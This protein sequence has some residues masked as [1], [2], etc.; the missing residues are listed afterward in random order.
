MTLQKNVG[1]AEQ[2]VSIWRN[3]AMDYY[4]RLGG[5]GQ[6]DGFE[7]WHAL[8][9]TILL[10]LKVNEFIA[11]EMMDRYLKLLPK[12]VLQSDG[13]HL[14]VAH[15]FERVRD[16]SSVYDSNLVLGEIMEVWHQL[17]AQDKGF[18]FLSFDLALRSLLNDLHGEDGDHQ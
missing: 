10:A 18:R 14:K 11:E 6:Y 3:S 7:K 1:L 5:A 17:T 15:E 2:M 8:G 4:S 13:L 9:L 12:E 16:Q